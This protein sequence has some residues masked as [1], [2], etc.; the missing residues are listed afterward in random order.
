[1]VLLPAL[2]SKSKLDSD[3]LK[4][5]TLFHIL[6]ISHI[7]ENLCFLSLTENIGTGSLEGFSQMW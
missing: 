5:R 1:M 4:A 6:R 3:C 2:A 7:A